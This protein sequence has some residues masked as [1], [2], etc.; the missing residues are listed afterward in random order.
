MFKNSN[1]NYPPDSLAGIFYSVS[2]PPIDLYY[3]ICFSF[4]LLIDIIIYSRSIK[5]AVFRSYSVFFIASLIGVSWIGLSGMRENADKFLI[6]G[7]YLSY[8]FTLCFL[9]CL[10]SYFIC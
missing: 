1:K 6:A 3:L 5:Q 9:F 2:F 10:R 7:G 8:L 4:V